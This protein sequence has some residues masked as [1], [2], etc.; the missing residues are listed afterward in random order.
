[1]STRVTFDFDERD[2]SCRSKSLAS[3]SIFLQCHDLPLSAL[4]A[5]CSIPE[6]MASPVS[7]IRIVVEEQLVP[8]RLSLL[9]YPSETFRKLSGKDRKA[10]VAIL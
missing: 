4:F 1:M 6:T 10:I 5:G 8:V 3:C 9:I 2:D 7:A